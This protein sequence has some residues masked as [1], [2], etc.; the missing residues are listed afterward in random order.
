MTFGLVTWLFAAAVTAHNAEEAIWLPAWSRSA[1]KW[2]P[3]VTAIEFR[4]ATAVLTLLAILAAALARR[5]DG[6]AGAYLVAGYALAM[7]LNVLFPHLLAT[8]T[9]RRYMPG[10]VTAV[11]L[12]MPASAALLWNAIAGGYID[13]QRFL[14]TGPATVAGIAISIPLLFW[15]GRRLPQGR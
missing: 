2:H 6:S 9:L 11:L 5:G 14:W 7:L 1:G 4:F 8:L 10:T 12:I 15:L 3:G 13:A